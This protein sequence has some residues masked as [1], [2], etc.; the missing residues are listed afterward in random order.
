MQ[1]VAAAGFTGRWRVRFDGDRPDYRVRRDTD[2]LTFESDA[3]RFDLR[4]RDRTWSSG[5]PVPIAIRSQ[6]LPDNLRR[7]WTIESGSFVGQASEPSS[8]RSALRQLG[9]LLSTVPFHLLVPI[10]VDLTR[11]DGTVVGRLR[12]RRTFPISFTL[13][14]DDGLLH[15]RALAA[16]A[17]VVGSGAFCS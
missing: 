11:D 1:V 8:G 12:S 7:L 10:S 14:C 2:E 4:H 16:V 17:V 6:A 9:D 15:P 3:D 13:T 5:G